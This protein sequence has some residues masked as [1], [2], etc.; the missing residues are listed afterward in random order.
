MRCRRLDRRTLGVAALGPSS[1]PAAG[2]FRAPDA[3]LGLARGGRRGQEPGIAPGTLVAEWRR[4]VTASQPAT[5]EPHE[6]QRREHGDGGVLPGGRV[7]DPNPSNRP[8][9]NTANETIQARAFIMTS[10]KT[11]QRQELVSRRAT[12]RVDM[13][14]QAS[15]KNTM[16]LTPMSGE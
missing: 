1:P 16:R 11:G 9:W 15:T 12:A 6:G 13:H 7:H 10:M 2:E 4:P 14:W 3:G 8:P 5:H